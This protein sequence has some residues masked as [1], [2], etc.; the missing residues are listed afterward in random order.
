MSNKISISNS[1]N[2]F[3]FNYS[4]NNQIGKDSNID[5]AK[6]KE[7]DISLNRNEKNIYN[8][9]KSKNELNSKECFDNDS[10]YSRI[11]STNEKLNQFINIRKNINFK[12]LQ[13]EDKSN[14][15]MF[16][17]YKV[18]NIL[19]NDKD[20]KEIEL[21][22]Y[23][24]MNSINDYKKENISIISNLYKFDGMD[25]EYKYYRRI[26]PNGNS[27]YIS[28]IYQYFKYLIKNNNESTLSYIFNIEKEL[29][30]FFSNNVTP[31]INSL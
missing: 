1:S 6:I 27:F 18:I 11:L 15:S 28:F 8:K 29:S 12:M 19:K 17:N 4:I 13:N 30:L 2:F 16:F 24:Q 25:N 31:T 14:S 26:K 23:T 3:L 22:L 9:N 20:L 21:N 7:Y 5:L 10:F